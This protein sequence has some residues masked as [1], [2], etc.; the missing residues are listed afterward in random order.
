MN[1]KAQI[2][3]GSTLVVF[4]AILV[5]LT[6]FL[7]IAQTTGSATTSVDRAITVQTTVG[8]NGARV[9]LVGQ[10]LLSTPV[11]I[12]GSTTLLAGNYTIDE[13]VSETTGVK[14]ISYLVDDAEF[15]SETLNISYTYGPD[16]YVNNSGS[17]AMVGIIAIFFALAV[18]MIAMKPVLEGMAKG[19]FGI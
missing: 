7:T 5:G 8:A 18:A 1:N 16:G 9:D 10:D 13:I 19:G 12:N 15:A 11:V 4:I 14:T 2:G 17:R 6:L 3:I